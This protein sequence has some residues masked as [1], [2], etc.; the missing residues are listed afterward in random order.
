MGKLWRV[1]LVSGLLKQT[2]AMYFKVAGVAK[3]FVGNT[4]QSR[5]EMFR[6]TAVVTLMLSV[7]LTGAIFGRHLFRDLRPDKLG[8][9]NK[10][11]SWDGT[12]YAKIAETGYSWSPF[13]G[14]PNAHYQSVA[15]FPFYPWI[16][17]IFSKL[18]AQSGPLVFHCYRITL[19]DNFSNTL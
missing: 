9:A 1:V 12:W 3:T 5:C 2:Q 13:I 15:F 8:I 11:L 10:M 18:E 4:Q 19:R 7:L 6:L 16:L 14:K 17:R